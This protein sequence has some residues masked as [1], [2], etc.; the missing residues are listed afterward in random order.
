MKLTFTCP[1]LGKNYRSEKYALLGGYTIADS[2]P[3]RKR[4]I[5]RVAVHDPCPHC[6]QHHTLG[7]E[8]LACPLTAKDHDSSDN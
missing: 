7:V 8:D 1:L 2:E 6:G 4:L 5:G 3:G